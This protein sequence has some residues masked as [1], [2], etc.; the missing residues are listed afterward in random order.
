M[1]NN[2]GK[3]SLLMVGLSLILSFFLRPEN[4]GPFLLGFALFSIVGIVFACLSKKRSSIIGGIL[5]NGAVLIFF[6]LLVLGMGI[7][8]R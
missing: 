2:F 8:E 5:L 3:L 4:A 1:N 6:S 7:G